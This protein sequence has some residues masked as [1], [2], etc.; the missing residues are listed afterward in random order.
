[1]PSH[2]HL[3]FL[4]LFGNVPGTTS[5]NLNPGLGEEGAGRQSE[6]DVYEHMDGVEEGSGQSMG[7]GHVIGNASDCTKL[8]RII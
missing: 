1:M 8:R 3:L 4:Q 5:G 7:R 2:D 6:D